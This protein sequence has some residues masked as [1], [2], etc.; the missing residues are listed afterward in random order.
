MAMISMFGLGFMPE[1]AEGTSSL[2][3]SILTED[4]QNMA[5]VSVPIT[6]SAGSYSVVTDSSGRAR[7]D[8]ASGTYVLD[9][10]I[11]GYDGG[12]AQTVVAQSREGYLVV[13]DLRLP[14][15]L[16]DGIAKR[17]VI[18]ETEPTEADGADGDLWFVY[19]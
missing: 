16:S 12:S 19:E 15:V 13:F 17:I 10:G 4:R 1:L 8:V 18:S 7:I 14:R 11:E 3:I 9:P 2:S 5:G 6:G